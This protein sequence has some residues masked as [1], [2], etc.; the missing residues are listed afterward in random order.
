[1]KRTV[2]ADEESQPLKG[3]DP[4]DK[5]SQSSKG[6]DAV[7][8]ANA[9]SIAPSSLGGSSSSPANNPIFLAKMVIRKVLSILITDDEGG[10]V[11]PSVE[12]YSVIGFLKDVLIGVVMGLV[13]ISL[14]IF[15][16]H[17]NVIHL[18]S[19]HN[20]RENAFA[21]LNDPETIANLEEAGV[22]F[23]TMDQY[24][25]MKEELDGADEKIED[26]KEKVAAKVKEMAEIEAKL[27]PIKE[28]YE[29]RLAATTLPLD[30]WCGTCAWGGGGNCDARKQYFIDTYGH[31]EVSAKVA[32]MKQSPKCKNE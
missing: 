20:F 16:D 2:H 17:I 21:M 7:P 31:G 22:K 19:A 25:L 11:G 6:L 27:G 26:M 5:E 10:D 32:I 8:P 4:D 13:T 1:M 3:L 28:E 23:I 18:Q 24:Q 15:L 14:M 29:K 30:K 12:G 9:T